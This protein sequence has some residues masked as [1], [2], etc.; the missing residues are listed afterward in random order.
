[1][2]E[3]RDGTRV[4]RAGRGSADPGAPFLAGP[5]FAAPFHFAGDARDEQYTYG[6]YHNP[7]WTAFERALSDLEGGESLVFASGMAAVTAVFATAL[8]PGDVL[9]IPDDCYYAT[10][11]LADERLR[12]IG[13]ALRPFATAS[14]DWNDA[15][16]GATLVWLESPT[17]PGLDVC[18]I[19]A[20][21]AAAH[22]AGAL[23]AVD[24]TTATVLGQN[25]LALGADFSVA[26][27][28][29]ALTGHADLVLGHVAC[30]DDAW[31]ARLRAYRTQT[32][33]IAGP[34]E[35][36]LAHRSLA[37]LDVRLERQCGN[38]LAIAAL[39][40][41][42][43]AAA[44]VR[45]PGLVNDAAHELAVRQMRRFGPVVSFRLA[46]R[47]HADRFFART[48]LVTEATS[49]GSVHTSAER[50]ARWGGDQV[51]QGFIRLSAG[52]EDPADLLED[53]AQALD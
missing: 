17:N 10:R 38:A 21:A 42:H 22:A 27:D 25:P 20:V 44:G 12:G 43:P 18:D 49:F 28:T 15:L 8:K 14:G 11:T 24:N 52:C 33:A 34:M 45:Y 2:S 13:I 19:A 36:W 23:V 1:M 31:A 30:A 5:T 7:T 3:D 46:D 39:L 50:R 40:Q 32:G 16:A 41:Q 26:S 53:I 4:L 6:R 29:K 35:V 48:R 47:A 51:S 37:T 9:V